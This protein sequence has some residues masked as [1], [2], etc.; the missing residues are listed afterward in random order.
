MGCNQSGE[1]NVL[2]DLIKLRVQIK[3]MSEDQIYLK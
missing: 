3:D 2:D 1:V